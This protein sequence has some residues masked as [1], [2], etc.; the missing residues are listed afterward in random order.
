MI[1]VENLYKQFGRVEALRGLSFNVREGSAFALIG[2]NGAG[3]TTVIKILMNILEPT[4]GLATILGADSRRISPR[5]LAQIGYVSENQ[6]MPG[7]L[8][9]AE[10]VAYLRPFYFS[11]DRDLE[12]DTFRQLRLPG[13]RKIADLSHGMRLK[14][15]LLCAL[16]YRPKLLILDE[17]FSGLDP[18][19]RDEFMEGLLAQAGEMTILVSS[20]ELGEIDGVATDIGFLDEGKLLFQESMAQLSGRFREVRVTLEHEAAPPPQVPQDWLGVQT[21]GNVLT[22]IESSFDENRLGE[23]VRSRLGEV[24]A[25]DSQPMSLRSIFTTLARAARDRAAA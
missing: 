24:R 21:L 2:A 15:A 1:H 19:V 16:P 18:L 6:D 10:Y 3:K 9:V 17:P 23:L 7:R 11:W 22:F 5:E 25:I 12:R 14:M 20:H 8:T 13:D 4:R